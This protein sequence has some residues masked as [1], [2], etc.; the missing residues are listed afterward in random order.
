M[1]VAITGATGSVGSK[2]VARHL[3]R[4]DT[5][6][7]LTRRDDHA[8]AAPVE[9]HR[10]DLADRDVLDRLVDGT[11]VLYHCAAEIQEPG[12]MLAVNVGGTRNLVAAAHGR[13]TRWVQL[14]SIGV[15][16]APRAGVVDEAAPIQPV[17]VYGRSKAEADALVLGAANDGAFACALVRPTKVYGAGIASGNNEILYR[18]FSLVRRRLFFFIGRPGALAHYVHVDNLVDALERCARAEFTG[19]RVYNLS[20]DRT[21]EAFVQVIADALDAPVPTLRLPQAPLEWLARIFGRIPGFPLDERRL[22][23]LVNRAA[24]PSERIRRELGYACPVPVEQGLRE[25]AVAW[26][27]DA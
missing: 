26:R 11:D 5:V 10:G 7:A 13:V 20:D 14:S 27:S 18:L 12:R 15:Y 4:G 2:L 16:G 8:L 23:A 9:V 25:L 24:I 3:S 21:I 6:R 22:A 1:I 19:S 17:D